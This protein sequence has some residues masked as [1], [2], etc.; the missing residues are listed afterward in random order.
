MQYSAYQCCHPRPHWRK[1]TTRTKMHS[2]V[3]ET[4]ASTVLDCVGQLSTV[5]DTILGLGC[6][7]NWRIPWIRRRRSKISEEPLNFQVLGARLS[8]LKFKQ[9]LW[10]S[11]TSVTVRFEFSLTSGLKAASW[12]TMY[13]LYTDLELLCD[14]FLCGSIRSHVVI[15]RTNG[16]K[17]Y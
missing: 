15:G 7:C 14:R 5:C 6:Q 16:A 4:T 8:M 13:N 11:V 17:C 10:P 3:Q 1:S 2:N 12:C 9:I